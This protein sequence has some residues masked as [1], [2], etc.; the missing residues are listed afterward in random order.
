MVSFAFK[1]IALDKDLKKSWNYFKWF[2][3]S[4]KYLQHFS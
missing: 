2:I 1:K 3:V 4:S